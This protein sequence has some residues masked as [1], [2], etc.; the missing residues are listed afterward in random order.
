MGSQFFQQIFKC[1]FH[2]SMKG[3]E[4]AG[5]GSLGIT[6]L[7]RYSGFLVSNPDKVDILS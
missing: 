7:P 6:C 4:V 3:F 1:D 2:V 5:L